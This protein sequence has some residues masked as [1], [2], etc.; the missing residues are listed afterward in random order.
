MH[1]KNC[2]FCGC[3]IFIQPFWQTSEISCHSR[4][5][6]FQHRYRKKL[7]KKTNEDPEIYKI[8]QPKPKL[9]CYQIWKPQN[10]FQH[11]T[12]KVLI[13]GGGGK[14]LTSPL[15]IVVPLIVASCFPSRRR[16]IC[17]RWRCRKTLFIIIRTVAAF[18]KLIFSQTGGRNSI[19]F[20]LPSVITP[21]STDEK[22]HFW[23]S[24][25]SSM[26]IFKKNEKTE[27]L[28]LSLDSNYL[29]EKIYHRQT[30]SHKKSTFNVSQMGSLIWTWSVSRVLIW[31]REVPT[32]DWQ[33]IF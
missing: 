8:C 31:L 24:S 14:C 25:V 4:L 21:K 12:K 13:V 28:A 15:F 3:S 1:W 11:N 29:V 2:H 16:G 26:E 27:K 6:I 17:E 23:P 30:V 10:T 9:S 18:V 32:F 20:I 33:N 7:S 22:N 19:F 5:L